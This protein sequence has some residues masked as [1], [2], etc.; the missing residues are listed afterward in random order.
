MVD[1]IVQTEKSEPLEGVKVYFISK[2]APEVK[3]TDS[4]GYAQIK[5]PPR[6]NIDI[7]LSKKG[8]QTI[9]STINLEINKDKTKVL[10]LNQLDSLASQKSG[11]SLPTAFVSNPSITAYPRQTN[12]KF[13]SSSD[14][15]LSNQS[16]LFDKNCQSNTPGKSLDDILKKPSNQSVP[17]GRELLPLIAYMKSSGAVIYKSEPVEFVCDVNSSFQE[18]KLVFG[19]HGGNDYALPGNKLLFGVYL[20]GNLAGTKAVVVGSKQE[21]NLNLQGV[22]NVS[23]RSECTSNTCPALSFA[24][25]SLK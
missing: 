25:M 10:K 4:N 15:S 19:V 2:G 1:L 3:Y 22:K 11:S 16:P 8:F 13:S 12:S 14:L 21:W 9:T 18:L 17:L 24:E 23:L 20:N 5:I 6:G 7:N